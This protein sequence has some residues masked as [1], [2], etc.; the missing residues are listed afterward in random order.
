ML[1]LVRAGCAATQ[2]RAVATHTLETQTRERD[3]LCARHSESGKQYRQNLARANEPRR[4]NP[5]TGTFRGARPPRDRTGLRNYGYLRTDGGEEP[6]ISRR[7]WGYST[8]GRV[9]GVVTCG[10]HPHEEETMARPA[11]RAHDNDTILRAPPRCLGLC[12]KECKM[13]EISRQRETPALPVCSGRKQ[14]SRF[15]VTISSTWHGGVTGR[16]ER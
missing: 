11:A 16:P 10:S 8:S 6:T 13:S 14:C 3:G 5:R 7:I 1:F 2:P 9:T 4:P 15:D 12:P